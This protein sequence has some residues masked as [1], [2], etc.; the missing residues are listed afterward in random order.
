MDGVLH[1][2]PE[3]AYLVERNCPESGLMKQGR[4]GEREGER[5]TGGPQTEWEEES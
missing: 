5:K 1:P 3:A 4:K 2:S